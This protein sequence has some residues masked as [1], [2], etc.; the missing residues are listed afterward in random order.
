MTDKELV[1]KARLG[2]IVIKQ[3]K[4]ID[5]SVCLICGV[6]HNNIVEW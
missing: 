5:K 1:H 2:L 3:N 6:K 4:L